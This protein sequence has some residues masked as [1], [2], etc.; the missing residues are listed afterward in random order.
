M[1]PR[2]ADPAVTLSARQRAALLDDA[3]IALVGVGPDGLIRLV[4]RRMCELVGRS[5]QDLLGEPTMVYTHP[6]DAAVTR[7][8][9]QQMPG[10]EG[11]FEKRVLRPDGGVCWVRITV[12]QDRM[13]GL[14]LGQ[15][16][17]ITELVAARESARSAAAAAAAAN[18]R[19]SALVEHSADIVAV[20][21]AEGALVDSNPAGHRLL[22]WDRGQWDGLSVLELVH[23]DDRA[24][25]AEGF[26]RTYSA[27]G[28]HPPVSFRLATKEGGWL[29]VEAIT[30]NQLD[31]PDIA[32]VV[33]NVHD[34]TTRAT[35]LHSLM[36]S[37]S[38]A[39]EYRD[40]YTAGHQLKVAGIAREIGVRLGLSDK[41]CDTIALGA[42]IHDIGKIAIPAEILTKPGRL[43]A[44]EETMMRS[45]PQVGFDILDG[46]DFAE[47][48]RD[49]V[50]H[51]H[52]RLDGSGYPHGLQRED[53]RL[54][55]RIVAVADVVDAMAAHRPYRPSL[56]LA[57]A[58]EELRRNSGTLYDEDVVAAY[59]EHLEAPDTRGIG[60]P[61]PS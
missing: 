24:V 20:L 45:H 39:T 13:S 23:P 54:E 14:A 1:L 56:G 6:G 48:V 40:P 25:I 26:R 11:T 52:E 55:T 57:A 21:D 34:V 17:D 16:I 2:Q 46:I 50:L 42:S 5:E 8:V 7:E 27:P 37:L 10:Y 9:M 3:G 4:N 58:C 61:A 53:I 31:D 47:P 43:S 12:Q 33:V 59:L 60:P 18:R 30:N 28:L 36:L 22:G 38:R 19:A 49:I 35:S 51:H 15:V 29:H 41:A 44:A 32:G